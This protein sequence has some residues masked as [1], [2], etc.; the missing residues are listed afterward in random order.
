MKKRTAHH[1]QKV[2]AKSSRRQPPLA[3]NDM[4][5]PASR[6]Y[7]DYALMSALV[8]GTTD[9]LF[10]KDPNG[11]YLM[12]NP[13]G[14]Q[15]IGQPEEKI[16]GKTDEDLFPA[17]TAHAITKRDVAV[18][19]SGI[20]QTFEEALTVKG[21]TR[22]Y[23]TTKSPY[24]DENGSVIGLV[25]TAHDITERKR[26]ESDL[27]FF[28]QV[29]AQTHDPIYWLSPTDGFRIAYANEAACRH[30]GYLPN[31]LRQMSVPELDPHF[32]LDMCEKLW[33]QLR[34]EKSKTFE[35]IHRRSTGELVPVE[36][37][38]NFVVFGS[39][40]YAAG[41]IRNITTRRQIEEALRHERDR[42]H[43][44]LQI[45][46]VIL[47][48]LN[49]DATVHLI[50]RKGCEV[51]GYAEK[52]I[53]GKNWIDT[54]IPE[55]EREDIRKV[56]SLLLAGRLA[57]AERRQ[58]LILTRDRQERIIAW[59]NTVLIDDFG[60]IIGTLSSGEDIT[61]RKRVEDNLKDSE[62][63][64][65]TVIKA[66]ND[67][68]WEWDVQP[69]LLWLS[70]NIFEHFGYRSSELEPGAEAWVN[71]LHP[72]DR[73][74]VSSVDSAVRSR[75][76]LWSGEYRFLRADGSYA[77]VYHRGYI[78]Y[79]ESGAPIRMTGALMD[80]TER[81]TAEAERERLMRDRLLLLNSTD[82]GI[83]GIDQQAR[84]AFI[85]RSGAAM[86]GY[87]PEELL[88]KN[89]HTTVHYCHQDGSS[90]PQQSCPIIQ[91]SQYGR[92]F[93][94]D[95][96]VFWRKDG[97]P[98]PVEYSS[99]PIIEDGITT[100]AVVTFTD[101][102]ERK[103]AEEELQNR[104]EQLWQVLVERQKLGRDLHDNIIQK[105]YAIGMNLEESK[106]TLRDHPQIVSGT[107]ERAILD[108]NIVIK[109]VR[110]Y[111]AGIDLGA[112]S[113]SGLREELGNLVKSTGNT[114]LPR[115]RLRID[116]RAV[117]SL[118]EEEARHVLL[119]T[120]EALSNSLRHSHGM[121]G[122]ISL[123]RERSAVRL[124]VADDGIGFVS[125]SG[126]QSGYGLQNMAARA[127][128]LGGHFEVLSVPGRGTRILVHIP[129]I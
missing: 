103:L 83:Y 3:P 47:V 61:D 97:T 58:N 96:E 76:P 41:T 123:R 121:A 120:R 112:L 77:H 71:R 36:V 33:N 116:P 26:A 52:E 38:T 54:F 57:A 84:C 114:Q 6:S 27:E 10:L 86:L 30:F 117:D 23:L 46:G 14:T 93:R 82:Q 11:R 113:A 17:E 51:L 32:S 128:E 55:R 102:S 122:F 65:R 87:T 35:T 68:V 64:F 7:D 59:N 98:F 43:K 104:E 4:R 74:I 106:Q 110:N 126:A 125:A 21:V 39:K 63:R 78:Q 70:D 48:V 108:L 94:L 53:I 44:Y 45:A 85:N 72:A 9:A 127:Q 37:T 8:R 20:A 115:F 111:I 81:K 99:H 73:H 24:R 118:T 109:D 88:G 2:R 60:K 67:V 49:T 95:H 28:K 25:G 13:A 1:Q 22:V 19:K 100:G 89:M 79:E 101:I 119:I 12:I 91:A 75:Q 105:V 69:N 129:K 18:M 62:T 34:V 15:L 5:S 90:Y 40:E 80:I 50:N 29:I 107:L 42:T 124:E 56:F 66:T 31:E 92:G 16:I